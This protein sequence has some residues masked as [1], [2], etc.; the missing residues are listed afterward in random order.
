MSGETEIKK[1]EETNDLRSFGR[2]AYQVYLGAIEE[3]ASPREAI[4]VTSAW[5]RGMLGADVPPDEDE[6]KPE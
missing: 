4:R 3:G 6:D 5:F 2:M 1:L